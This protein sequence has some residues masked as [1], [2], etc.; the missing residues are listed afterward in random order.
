MIG[1]TISHYRY[2]VLSREPHLENLRGE[3]RF[4]K[5]LKGV[6]VEWEQFEAPE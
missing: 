5:L 6:K 2:P 4:K 3:E 1:K